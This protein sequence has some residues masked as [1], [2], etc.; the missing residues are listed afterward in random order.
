MSPEELAEAFERSRYEQL[1][2][3]RWDDLR[4]GERAAR[5]AVA[6]RALEESGVGAEV[7]RLRV[8]AADADRLA[9]VIVQRDAEIARRLTEHD[10]EIRALTS[11]HDGVVAGLTAQLE[12]LGTDLAATLARADA[13]EA[14]EATAA[15]VVAAVRSALRQVPGQVD[16]RAPANADADADATGQHGADATDAIGHHGEEATDVVA[17]TV[18]AAEADVRAG[19][20][21][22]PSST[23]RPQRNGVTKGAMKKRFTTSRQ[24]RAGA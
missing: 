20:L 8:S 22:A 12:T 7:E 18:V 1:R 2:G 3:Q 24:A 16:R 4:D 10:E 11:T 5:T 6:L 23:S 21:S 13:A 9:A 19:D 15:S 14:Q 17:A